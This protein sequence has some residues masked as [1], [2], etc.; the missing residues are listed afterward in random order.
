MGGN[1]ELKKVDA[2]IEVLQARLMDLNKQRSRREIDAE[3]YNAESQ[4]VM[5]Q[6]TKGKR[7]ISKM[8]V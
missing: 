1:E 6:L 3:T 2:D 5:A 8:G 4:T 7:T